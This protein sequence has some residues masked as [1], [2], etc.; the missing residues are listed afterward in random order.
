MNVAH[1]IY[2]SQQ[3]KLTSIRSSKRLLSLQSTDRVTSL[4][5]WRIPTDT[6]QTAI[7]NGLKLAEVT[8]DTPLDEVFKH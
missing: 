5:I 7:S 8:S 6:P 4:K 2:T 1:V 3:S